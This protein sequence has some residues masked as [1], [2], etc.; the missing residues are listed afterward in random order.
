MS[1]GI[2]D[3]KQQDNSPENEDFKAPACLKFF[4]KWRFCSS[5]SNQFHQ[6]YIYGKFKD[7]SVYKDDM[8]NCVVY[9]TTKSETSKQALIEAMRRDEIKFTSADI[10][11]RR[12]N[13]SEYWN[14]H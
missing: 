14:S 5:S 8:Q 10:W 6:Y 1:T 4:E 12:E 13:P 3:E 9:K 7:C 2:L 11:E